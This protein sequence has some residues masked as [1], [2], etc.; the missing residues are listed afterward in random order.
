M[1]PAV[2][3]GLKRENWPW[4]ALHAPIQARISR[5][6]GSPRLQR[7]S[8]YLLHFLYLSRESHPALRRRWLYTLFIMVDANFRLKLKDRGLEDAEL[9]PRWAHY[10]ENS[11]FKAHVD[12]L[13]KQSDVSSS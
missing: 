11:K 7:S 10:V 9:G 3:P 8:E 5:T 13:G 12:S 6:D 2:P 4:T 1:T